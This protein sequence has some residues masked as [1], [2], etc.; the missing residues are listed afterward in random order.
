MGVVAERTLL[1]AKVREK[2]RE[3]LPRLRERVKQARKAQRQRLKQCKADCKA[4]ERKA[5]KAATVARK[6]L[7]QHIK[8][9]K[10][11]AGAICK[12]CKVVDEKSV[13]ELKNAVE[14]LN[15]EMAEVEQ[16][17]K[18]AGA[19]RSERGRKGGL[20][21]A[22]K[23][24]ESDSQVIHNLGDNEELIALFKKI[25]R[26]IKGSKHRSRT[27]AFFE[28]VHDNPSVLD[29]FRA[30]RERKWEK[31]AEK[32]FAE[33]EAPPCLDEL[34]DCRRALAEYE[35]AERFVAESQPEV[36]F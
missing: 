29:E 26:K 7:E 25:R 12:S 3:V 22:E 14:A 27:E 28:Y 8:R 11:R 1:R 5:K 36:P 24:Q 30:G 16:L 35:A 32:M 20:A 18:Q 4:A 6:K 10:K 34:A 9:A 31:E 15:K 2:R 13:T 17:Q 23:R 19:L 21:A 33:R